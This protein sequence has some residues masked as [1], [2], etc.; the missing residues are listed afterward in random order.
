M[1]EYHEVWL[2]AHP[3]RS[4]DWLKRMLKDGFDIHHINGS[5]DDNRA[6]NLVLIEFHDHAM[7]HG[8]GFSKRA[9]GEELEHMS[10]K[11][12][13]RKMTIGKLCYLLRLQEYKW[14]HINYLCGGDLYGRQGMNFAKYYAKQTNK[15]WPIR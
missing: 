8:T 13:K 4:R 3:H 10:Q 6:E 15:E 5:H 11:A 1:K 14:G 12:H 2:E 9:W 7:L